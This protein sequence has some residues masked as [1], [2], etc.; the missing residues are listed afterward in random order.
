VRFGFFDFVRQVV[1]VGVIPLHWNELKGVG[2]W[3]WVRRPVVEPGD[4]RAG[5]GEAVDWVFVVYGPAEAAFR[6]SHVCL[7]SKKKCSESFRWELWLSCIGVLIGYRICGCLECDVV[8]VI[9]VV[10]N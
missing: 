5:F 10:T 1:D 8:V 6:W 2:V 4:F 9:V 3:G 7:D